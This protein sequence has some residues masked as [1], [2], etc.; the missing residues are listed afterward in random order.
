MKWP[1]YVKN[2]GQVNDEGV[3]LDTKVNMRLSRVCGLSA[4]QRVSLT[5]QEFDELTENKKDE[6]FENFIQT[7]VQYLEELKLKRKRK[8][9]AMKIIYHTWRI[10]ES[11]L[12]MF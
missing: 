1:T 3:P 10:Y 7:Y 4:R 8:K 11:K 12:V 2:V 5:L 9:V 6:L